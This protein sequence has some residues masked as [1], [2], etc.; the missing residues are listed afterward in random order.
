MPAETLQIRSIVDLNSLDTSPAVLHKLLE[1][2]QKDD[3]NIDQ[4]IRLL[5]TD[6]G[7]T[8]RIFAICSNAEY[9]RGNPPE[10]LREAVIRLG[11][12]ELYRLAT[13]LAMRRLAAQPTLHYAADSRYF[14]HRTVTTAVAM[15]ELCPS[16]QSS[17]HAYTIGLMHLVGVWILSRQSAPCGEPIECTNLPSMAKV[18]KLRFGAAYAQIGAT[19][20]EGWGF[21]RSICEAVYWQNEP[22]LAEEP[23]HTAKA[24]LLQSAIRLTEA[25]LGLGGDAADLFSSR[26]SLELS[27][28]RVKTKTNRLI[29]ALAT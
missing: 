15:E 6:P 21:S 3:F 2:T 5:M 14:W 19:A 22:E 23:A 16:D 25:A 7:L 10:S 17:E 13:G 18:E 29:S 11:S 24:Q 20:L 26:R 28:A 1:L 9:G 12:R 27:I 4:A 8:A